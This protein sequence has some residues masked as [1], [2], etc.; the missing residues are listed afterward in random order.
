MLEQNGFFVQQ[1]DGVTKIINYTENTLCVY[2]K[3]IKPKRKLVKIFLIPRESFKIFDHQFEID[4]TTMLF[5][6]EKE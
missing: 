4:L 1:K 3:P 6:L 2:L 5:S